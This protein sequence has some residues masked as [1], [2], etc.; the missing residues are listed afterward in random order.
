MCNALKDDNF[1]KVLD[2]RHNQFSTSVIED[3]TDYNFMKTMQHNESLVNIDFRDNQ[4]FVKSFKFKLS[5]VMI[6]NLDILRGQGV[7]P[8]SSWIN[9]NVLMINETIQS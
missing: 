5:L 8:Q 4:C 6:R 9:K 3:T 1:L 7:I 2:M